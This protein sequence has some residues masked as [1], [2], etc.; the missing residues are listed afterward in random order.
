ME[1]NKPLINDEGGVM[2][3]TTEIK[4]MIGET[5]SDVVRDGNE[6]LVFKG[7]VSVTFYHD[8]DCC[9]SVAIEDICGDLED[10]VDT[11][12][13]NAEVYTTEK[14][15]EDGDSAT[16]TF[17]TFRTIKGTVTVRWYGSSNGYYSES[18]DMLVTKK[19]NE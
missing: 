19:G 11:P 18:V 13:I 3:K 10:L 15:D 2:G 12:M 17:Y 4:E 6:R 1:I 5:F 14:E 8:Q 7:N 16:Y 9:E